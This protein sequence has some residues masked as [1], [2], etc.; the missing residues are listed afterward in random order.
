[1]YVKDADK[2]IIKR[3][4]DE[5]KLVHRGTIRHNYPHCWR[6]DSPLIYRA[7]STW[8]VEIDKI[9]EKMLRANSQILWVPDHIKEGRFGKWLEN[10][11]DW[12]IGRNR[13]WG[14]PLP[15]WKNE[16]TG[17]TICVGSVAEL[18][19]LSGQKVTDIHK[20]FVDKITIPSPTGKGILTRVPE[21][22][23]C[24]FE[25]GSMPYAQKH[26]PFESKEWFDKNYPADFIAEGL[27]QTRGWFYTLVVL[28][29]ALFDKPAFKNVVVN[30]LIL[31]EDGQKMSKRKKNYPDPMY[32]IN[33]YGADALRLFMLGSPVVKGDDLRF[34]EKGVKEVLRTVILPIWN[35]YSFFTT[36]ARVD[37]WEP[38]KGGIKAPKNQTNPLDRWI[39]SS[40]CEMVEEIRE[41]MD[42]Y[43]LQKATNRFASFVDDLTNWYIRRSRRRFWKSQ[44]DKDKDDAYR[45]LHYV[46]ITFA[47]TACPFIPFITDEIYQNLKTEG[48][49]ESVHLCDYPEVEQ[50]LRDKDLETQMGHTITAVSLG[51]Y[52]RTKGELKVRQPLSKAVIISHEE[53]IRKLLN[54]TTDIIKEE[55]NV[56]EVEFMKNE[57]ELVDRHAK[58]NFKELGRKVGKDM[59]EVADLISKFD[60]HNINTILKDQKI[61]LKLSSGNKIEVG[62]EDVIIVRKEKEGLTVVTEKDITVALDTIVTKTLE[63]EGFAREFVSKIQNMRKD[64]NLD[65][66][67]R[68]ITSYEVPVAQ[69]QA[70]TN[71]SD[72]IKI[73]TLTTALEKVQTK[74]SD[75]E[76]VVINGINCYLSARKA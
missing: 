14:N 43:Q 9:K 21:V 50:S 59:K 31:S 61:A 66:S 37:N 29:A 55:L 2:I 44:N 69:E 74:K 36:Y 18:E 26:Y 73:E 39:L 52:L 22:L 75:S 13:Y 58:A 24:W 76:L 23:D 57:E 72:Y 32:I 25:S 10:A 28:G 60:N 48:M 56:K 51:R 17:E 19:K 67:D 12:N 40:L 34:S 71:F 4:K 27:D 38:E 8:F 33:E 68:I 11:R 45:I 35:S 3:L 64:M 20:H 1:M 65:V 6:D 16:D 47:K 42:H 53:H 46:L 30:G 5:G 49:P 15:I 41:S 63:E 54:E 70:I 7:I 62:K